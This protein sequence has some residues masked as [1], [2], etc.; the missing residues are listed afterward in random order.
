MSRAAR[1]GQQMLQGV[2]G[3]RVEQRSNRVVVEFGELGHDID[4]QRPAE[5]PR[6]ARG[7]PWIS[8]P[9]R[10]QQD[11]QPLQQQVG[12]QVAGAGQ[13]GDAPPGDA[14]DG[15]E[16][17]QHRIAAA[18]P[19][20]HVAQ[21][22]GQQ[23]AAGQRDRQ[24]VPHQ[25][26]IVRCQVVPGRAQRGEE[27]ADQ[28]QPVAG[29]AVAEVRVLAPRGEAQPAPEGDQRKAD[30]GC[31]VAKMRHAPE[32]RLVGEVVVAVGLVDRAVEQGGRGEQQGHGE[33]AGGVAG[34]SCGSPVD[35]RVQH[36]GGDDSAVNRNRRR[37]ACARDG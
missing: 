30:V 7:A 12:T 16:R 6:S 19:A 31:H 2:A 18:V 22:A 1:H 11:R 29:P 5:R 26:R 3:E 28:E 37:A 13:V 14:G 24:P 35:G 4:R 8:L 9:E 32:Q 20:L 21:H 15:G 33:S 25:A 34:V 17:Q 10:D 27:Q 36:G 23:A